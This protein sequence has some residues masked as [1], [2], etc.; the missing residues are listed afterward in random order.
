MTYREFIAVI[1]EGGFR[2]QYMYVSGPKGTVKRSSKADNVYYWEL[3]GQNIFVSHSKFYRL[4]N[5]ARD[6]H[7]FDFHYTLSISEKLSC[8]IELDEERKSMIFQ[9][10]GFI[11]NASPPKD[12]TTSE[13]LKYTKILKVVNKLFPDFTWDQYLISEFCYGVGNE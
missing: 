6:P 10:D 3:K 1:E 11:P 8:V 9:H 2:P 5:D 7:I 13:I 12:L 4:Q